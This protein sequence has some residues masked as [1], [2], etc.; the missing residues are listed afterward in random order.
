MKQV[1]SLS[2]ALIGLC[3]LTACGKTP[4]A[5]KINFIGIG[6]GTLTSDV[7]KIN[8]NQMFT[9]KER[10]LIAVVSFEKIE[11][12]STVQATWFSPD[13]RSIPLGRTPIVTQ[14]GARIARFSF[15][16][17]VDWKAAPYELRIDVQS[18][19]GKPPLT[20]S[21]SLHFFIGM[22]EKD[23]Q[24]YAQDYG[25]WMKQEDRQRQLGDKQVA[26]ENSLMAKAKTY[27]GATDDV[28][29]L[30]RK[31]LNA[32]GKDDYLVS[33]GNPDE[34]PINAAA[35]GTL[36]SGTLKQF[37]VVNESGSLVLLMKR[38]GKNAV[39][40]DGAQKEITKVEAAD[41][42]NI[43]ILPSQTIALSWANKE[44]NCTQ[45]IH[46][47]TGGGFTAAPQMCQ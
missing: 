6:T 30:L 42:V 36:F 7:N 14:S 33:P 45:E 24:A 11:D 29:I 5:P 40:T 43:V 20:T 23:I 8:F 2:L 31:D 10:Q 16:S 17:Q 46:R 32:D 37:A 12:G 13:E 39:L 22:T 9:V 41:A 21:G 15:A 27:L 38:S 4:V 1:G 3:I 34:M 47:V 28:S 18:K 26:L 19:N 44:K 25:A 35:P